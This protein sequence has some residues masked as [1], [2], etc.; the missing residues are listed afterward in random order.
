MG[1]HNIIIDSKCKKELGQ[2]NIIIDNKCKKEMGQHTHLTYFSE[3]TMVVGTSV[4]APS[5]FSLVTS[6]S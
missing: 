6:T 2:H 5:I 3:C 1:Q 4:H